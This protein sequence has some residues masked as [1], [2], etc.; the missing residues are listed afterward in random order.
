MPQCN[1]HMCNTKQKVIKEYKSGFNCSLDSIIGLP[2]SASK[3]KYFRIISKIHNSIIGTYNENIRENYSFIYLTNHFHAHSLPVPNIYHTSKDN[4]IYFI[5]DLGDTTLFNLIQNDNKQDVTSDKIIDYYKNAID[6]L[7]K[8]Q[9]TAD[10]DLDYSYCYPVPEFNRAAMQWDL[11]YFKYLFLKLSSIEFEEDLLETDFQ[12]LLNFLVQNKLNGFVYRD[13]QSRN[14]MV[15]NDNLF[16]IDYQGGRKG[17][18]QYDIVSLVLDAKAN[19]PWE[20]KNE[21]VDY[22]YQNLK[23]LIP[24]DKESFYEQISAN[25]LLR[26]MQTFGT[27]GY[28]GWIEK[29]EHF[30]QSIPFAAKNLKVIIN[31]KSIEKINIPYLCEICKKIILR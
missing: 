14:I 8:F 28:R 18:L 11:N 5:E 30:V 6:Y 24:V 29:K 22:Y 16:F 21:L 13:F 25:M 26:I 20:T 3:R 23:S 12:K 31:N 27:Y 2:A 17:P 10:K 7:M 15:K 4:L 1:S 19:L 9:L